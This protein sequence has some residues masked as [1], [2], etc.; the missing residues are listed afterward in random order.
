M[1]ERTTLWRNCDTDMSFQT[2]SAG[3]DLRSWDAAVDGIEDFRK[4]GDGTSRACMHACRKVACL[5]NRR[6]LSPLVVT[7][8]NSSHAIEATV[9][10]LCAGNQDTTSLLTPAMKLVALIR[11]GFISSSMTVTVRRRLYHE[12]GPMNRRL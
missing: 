8:V 2:L 6:W 3:P 10:Q 4:D 1:A 7:L 11:F 5:G 12:D 9:R